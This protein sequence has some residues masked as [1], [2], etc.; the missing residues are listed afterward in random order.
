MSPAGWK[1]GVEAESG[2]LRHQ[3]EWTSVVDDPDV[4]SIVGG[5]IDGTSG[6][7]LLT[8]AAQD[9][10]I[11]LPPIGRDPNPD[12]RN[13]SQA[14]CHGM[15]DD[16][17]RSFP[18]RRATQVGGSDVQRGRVGAVVRV[19][20][21]LDGEACRQDKDHGAERPNESLAIVALVPVGQDSRGCLDAGLRDR[22]RGIVFLHHVVGMEPEIGRVVSKEARDVGG[23]REGAVI[24]IFQRLQEDGLDV[25]SIR[26]LEEAHISLAA[27]FAQKIPDV[28]QIGPRKW[29]G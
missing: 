15:G 25:Q 26:G 12:R 18:E 24:F 6:D 17:R 2:P 9:S 4:C 29:M 22:T 19:V 11:Y 28:A 3:A 1:G 14:Q 20:V 5:D 21:R 8:A 27:R 7:P 23:S 10:L 16:V 13:G